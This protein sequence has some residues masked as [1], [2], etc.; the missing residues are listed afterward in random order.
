MDIHLA[1]CYS[2]GLVPLPPIPS[3]P[4]FQASDRAFKQELAKLV[5]MRI[6]EAAKEAS[7]R[8]LSAR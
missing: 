7:R 1:C 2:R 6:W 8:E 4:S 5:D 3:H